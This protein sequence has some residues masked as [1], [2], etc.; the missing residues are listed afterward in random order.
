M[1]LG[2]AIE[3]R[4]LVLNREIAA[5]LAEA[6]ELLQDSDRR[7]SRKRPRLV[8]ETMMAVRWWAREDAANR[9]GANP[10]PP[11]TETRRKPTET[12][13]RVDGNGEMLDAMTSTD[14]AALIDVGRA[15]VC[16]LARTG[17]LPGAHTGRTWTFR[18]DAVTAYLAGQ[19]PS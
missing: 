7:Q 19:D 8:A 4:I 13:D 11:P 15:R 6:I 5:V 14:V 18:R 12:F 1:A 9:L 17:A 16:Q 10:Q 2:A 3:G